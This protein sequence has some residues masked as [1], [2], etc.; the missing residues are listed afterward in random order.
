MKLHCSLGLALGFS[1]AA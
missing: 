1:C